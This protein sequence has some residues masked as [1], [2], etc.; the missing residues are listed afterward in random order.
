MGGLPRPQLPPGPVRDLFEALHALH[1]RAGWPS[2][3]A[4][5]REVGC[6]HT[7]VAAA[8][9]GPGPPRW[10][11]LEL[12][13][14][15]LNG[16]VE[17]FHRLWLA[18]GTG[19]A[20]ETAV[21]GPP[22]A[23]EPATAP[24]AVVPP[25]VPVPRQ[26]PAD[27]PA[28]TGREDQLTALDRLVTTPAHPTG[29]GPVCAVSGTAGVGKTTL[30]VHWAHRVAAHFPDGQLHLDLR[31]YD[32]QR[33]VGVDEALETLL[34]SL[35]PDGAAVPHDR[36]ERA[37]RWR[38]L[39]ADRRVLILL[40]N[41][42]STVQVRD[43]LPGAGRSLVL[44]T[45]RD[46]LAGLVARNGAVRLNVDVLTPAEA[47]TLLRTP[48]GARVDA[49]PDA[50][51]RLA[52]L[53]AHLPL[54]L[55][56]AAEMATARPRVTLA[57]LAAELA[58]DARRLDLLAAGDDEYTAVRAVFSWSCRHLSAA[59]DR[60]F[61]LLGFAPCRR[62]G[63]PAAAALL[64]VPEPVARRVLDGLCRGHLVE[65]DADNRFGMHDLLRSYASERVAELAEDERRAAV[66][67]LGDH[68]L[69][70]AGRAAAAAFPTTGDPTAGARAWLDRERAN[71]LAMAAADPRHVGRLS[72]VLAVYLDTCAHYADGV[73]L[74]GAALVAARAA[75]DRSAEATAANLLGVVHRRL[76]DYDTAREHHLTALDLHRATGDLAGQARARQGLGVLS[77]R[78]GHYAE[79][80]DHLLDA[81]ALARRCGDLAAQGCALYALGTVH[82]HLGE[83]P[84]AVAHHRRALEVHRG[85]GDHLGESRTLNNLGVALERLGRLEEAHHHYRRSL[86]LNRRVGNHVGV[87]VSLTNLGSTCTKLGRHDE[88]RAH[89]LAAMPV[90]RDTGYRV[91]E[92][93]GLCGLGELHLRL[94]E[95]AEAER[96]FRRA[97]GI[98]EEVGEVELA[99]TALVGLGDA[100]RLAGRHRE[101]RAH[102]TGAL[103]RASRAGNRYGR[104]TA[105]DGLARLHHATGDAE[106]EAVT[107]EALALYADLG[108]P[109]TEEL[110][111][112]VAGRVRPL[113]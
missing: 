70:A 14:E 6:S 16:D 42:H 73:V 105:L 34:R 41:A 47:L 96:D 15:T 101:A 29:P 2:L 20:G 59:E 49:E 77:W 61:R 23:P 74:H 82:L 76:G 71:L 56:I 80:R 55:R 13:V 107:R 110:R 100:A 30:A 84:A 43:L 38:T 53:C 1:H 48:L 103:D 113:P 99:T 64:G 24:P 12:I 104:A 7:T 79:A 9:A 60:A 91:G 19:G 32:P 108:L 78:R 67:R 37:A 106:A 50:A 81:L 10:G 98:A 51:A 33:P 8:F 18:A 62:F 93:D 26:L 31:G 87:A 52:G 39:L 36:A 89:H 54:A 22:A 88:A 95:P 90:Y 28:F 44:I 68:Y 11:L 40:D 25:P 46:S 63:V 27:V 85:T 21:G 75:G 66:E 4:M 86:D 57:H 45:S 109:P 72:E 102:Y 112:L 69:A 94:G 92:T 83:Y 97:L 5:A 17:S 3:R 111:R 58:D 65:E 35:L